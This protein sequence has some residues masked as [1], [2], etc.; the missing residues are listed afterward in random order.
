MPERRMTLEGRPSKRV[1]VCH[2]TSVHPP[3]D[4]RIFLKECRTLARSGYEVFLVVPCHEAVEREGISVVPV[5]VPRNRVLRILTTTFGVLALALKTKAEIYHFHDPELIPHGLILKLF[6]KKVVYDVHE[7]VP[8]DILTK[9][10]LPKPI[11]PAISAVANFAEFVAATCF[12]CVVPATPSI[13]KR[14][15]RSKQRMV[16]NFP[17]ATEF[18]CNSAAYSNRSNIIT[19]IGNLTRIRGIKE[20]V[21]AVVYSKPEL[22][23][24]VCLAGSFDN[25]EF[26]NELRS[27]PGWQQVEYRGFL[28]R[29]DVRDLL[30]Q[31]RIGI[32][33]F[34][35]GPNHDEALP[36]KLF[37]YMSAG[38]PIIASDFLLWRKIITDAGC[39]IVVN[40]H[41]PKQ[42]GDAISTLLQDTGLAE[43]MGRAGM[44]AVKEQY[45]WEAEAQHL[46]AAYSD[47]TS[48]HV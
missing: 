15:P 17:L 42:V 36:N 48:R 9:D 11:R 39:G 19:Y 16:R 32:V 18:T 37:E 20:I 12:D 27:L 30:S 23:A 47:L 4:A 44:A 33:L 38:I 28:N 45:N 3:F 6:G 34:H 40:P 46:L 14:F 8:Q 43:R 10:W 21:D 26:E 7:D 5:K 24:R 41:D 2:L 29:S 13:A 22:N 35:P 31:T 25:H 1:V